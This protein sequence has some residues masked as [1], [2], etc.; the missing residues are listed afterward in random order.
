MDLQGYWP[1]YQQVGSPFRRAARERAREAVLSRLLSRVTGLLLTM[2][3]KWIACSQAKKI[4]LR[5]VS[6]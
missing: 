3:P 2:F 6:Q 5:V 4:Q 1:A